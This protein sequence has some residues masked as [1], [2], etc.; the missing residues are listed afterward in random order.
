MGGSRLG[1]LR[2]PDRP[3]LAIRVDDGMPS[4]VES[5]GV[6]WQSMKLVDFEVGSERA[7]RPIATGRPIVRTSSGL[8]RG[9]MSS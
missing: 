4:I 7:I 5:D 8:L 1:G 3:D 6:R 9:G 2:D